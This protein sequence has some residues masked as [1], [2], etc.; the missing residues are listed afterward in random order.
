MSILCAHRLRHPGQHSRDGL[1]A[2]AK[3][4]FLRQ[5]QLKKTI[6]LPRQARDK[7][8]ESTQKEMSCFVLFCRGSISTA[9]RRIV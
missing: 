3:R 4:I 8:K 5:F 6:I 1:A 2:G 7:H 9:R